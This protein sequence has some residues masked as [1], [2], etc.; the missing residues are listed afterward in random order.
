MVGNPIPVGK[1][2][3]DVAIT[4]DGM[5]LYLVRSPASVSILDTRQDAV[6]G[7]PIAVEGNAERIMIAS[8][9]TRA[10]V[11]GRK[12]VSIID[13]ATNKLVGEPVEFDNES[14]ADVLGAVSPDGGYI[15]TSYTSYN[16]TYAG[17]YW[18]TAID[19]NKQT[20]QRITLNEGPVGLAIS[21]DGRKLYIQTFIRRPFRYTV[22]VIDTTT[23]KFVGNP[24]AVGG[25]GA[26]VASPDGRW[27][28]MTDESSVEVL[29][30]TGAAPAET[31]GLYGDRKE[32]GLLSSSD[33]EV[34][35]DGR[36]LYVLTVYGT[37][38]IIEIDSGNEIEETWKLR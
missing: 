11:V 22:R 3:Q 10:F 29:D 37:I 19:V 18:V 14:N 24:I 13:T 17:P 8:D 33:L 4:P 1:Y 31:I 20:R 32:F 5:S 12:G 23:R 2:L 9:G 35:R 16:P 27:L 30:A 38:A 7:D 26:M 6:V 25:G 36:F 28:Y 21:P 15:Y 34:S